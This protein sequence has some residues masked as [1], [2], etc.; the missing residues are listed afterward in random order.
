MPK[1]CVKQGLFARDHDAVAGSH[2]PH[3]EVELVWFSK[4]V[5]CDRLADGFQILRNE[6]LKFGV[7]APE[8]SGNGVAGF[9]Q[10]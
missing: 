4:T 2:K 5:C 7:K 10:A 8:L 6:N 1:T 9:R 3:L